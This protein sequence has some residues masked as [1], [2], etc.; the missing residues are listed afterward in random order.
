MKRIELS[1]GTH[2]LVDD[3]K[4]EYLSQWS[5]HL[6]ASGYAYRTMTIKKGLKKTS[7]SIWMHRVVMNPQDGK[8][9]D[10]IDGNRL[11]KSISNLRACSH[12][13]NCFN[14]GL[15]SNNK[16]GYKG[17]FLQIA[18]STWRAQ[19]KIEGCPVN[20]GNYITP[21]DAAHVYD[22]AALQL[23]DEF[24]RTNFDYS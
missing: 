8:F 21:E 18:P 2:T 23:F 13:Q 6:S 22:Q 7:R 10:H 1:K 4:Y 12:R 5:W 19:L 14:A 16:S 15:R 3:D 24:A 9:V 17:V 11:D 20:L